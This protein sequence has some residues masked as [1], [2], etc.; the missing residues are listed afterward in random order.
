MKKEGFRNVEMVMP[1][2]ARLHLSSNTPFR[3]DQVDQF[4][5]WLNDGRLRM[6]MEKIRPETLEIVSGLTMNDF[7]RL[8]KSGLLPSNRVLMGYGGDVV[9]E[10]KHR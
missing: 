4:I 8:S 6:G 9:V 2:G 5:S 10:P 3:S 1:N 7:N